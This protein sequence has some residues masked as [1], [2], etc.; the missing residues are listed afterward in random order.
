MNV[1]ITGATGLI[2]SALTQKLIAEGHQVTALT[3]NVTAAVNQLGDHPNFISSL[4]ELP[5]LNAFNAVINLAGEP[6]ANKRWSHQQKERI[7]QSRW[8]TTEQLVALFKKSNTPPSVFISGSAVG[9]YGRQ[10]RQPI[11]ED[12]DSVHQNFSHRLCATWEDIAMRV[13]S[14]KTRVCLLRT[15]IV[16]S[17][18]GGA[19]K[20]LLFPFKLGLGGPI[21]A[22][23]HYM[24]WI[25]IDDMVDVILFLLRQDNC[26]GAFNV[27]APS[28][29]SNRAFAKLL[30]QALSRP[31]FL[32]TPPFM[33]KLL[34]G[35]MSELLLEGQNAIPTKLQQH[36]YQFHYPDL[37]SALSSLKL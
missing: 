7:Q 21:G 26:N 27:T 11:H 2:G 25:H 8:Q 36:G 5:N 10:G 1:L 12:T 24:P 6:I 18:N 19:L 14:S 15:G 34:F 9:Y 35:E 29:V 16:L 22:G 31:A 3:R 32:P 33:L 20:K 28:P 13:D 30:A 23:R 37:K 17:D 4:S